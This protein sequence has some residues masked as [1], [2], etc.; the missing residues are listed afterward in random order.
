M[1]VCAI[2]STLSW[3]GSWY[4]PALFSCHIDLYVFGPLPTI[5]LWYYKENTD[6]YLTAHS[7]AL[8]DLLIWVVEGWRIRRKK[9]VEWGCGI[10][11]CVASWLP[12]FVSQITPSNCLL[13]HDPMLYYFCTIYLRRIFNHATRRHAPVKKPASTVLRRTA[14]DLRG[15]RKNV[16]LAEP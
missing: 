14:S 8:C 4:S 5:R 13:L 11:G 16:R 10:L 15:W 2:K 12:S 1:W 7:I 9:M 3:E 6:K